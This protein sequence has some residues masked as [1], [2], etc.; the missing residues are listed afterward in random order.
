MF[1]KKSIIQL[2]FLLLCMKCPNCHKS[3]SAFNRIFSKKEN[4]GIRHCL[5]CG[6][7]VKFI[8]NYKKI[9]LLVIGLIAVLIVLNIL[10]NSAGLP[11]IGGTYLGILGGAILAIFMRRSPFLEIELVSKP[12]RKKR[13]N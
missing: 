11:S 10:F 4:N 13:R 12:T 6:A 5:S 1:E 3:S 9:F 2:F 7:Q 8:Y